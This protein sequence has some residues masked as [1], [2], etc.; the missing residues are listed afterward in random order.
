[1][2]NVESRCNQLKLGHP[3]RLNCG[4]YLPA[5]LADQLLTGLPRPCPHLGIARHW[6][7]LAERHF[8]ITNISTPCGCQGARQLALP[9]CGHDSPDAIRSALLNPTTCKRTD[10][11]AL[12]I[13]LLALRC[14]L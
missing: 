6:P 3:L 4:A 7:H 2:P 13:T 1:V 10:W 12:C 9:V 11:H 5:M 8:A 14:M